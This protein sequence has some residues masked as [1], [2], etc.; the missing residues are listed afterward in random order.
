M[1]GF[2]LIVG[3]LLIIED[4]CEHFT[5]VLFGLL[6]SNHLHGAVHIL[7]GIVGLFTGLRGDARSFCFFLG[8]LLLVVDLLWFLPA[9]NELIVRL[10]SV[11]Q[12][13]TIMNLISPSP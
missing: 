8:A 9:T 11:N 2:A 1:D 6:T 5:P 7:L 4:I 10:F 13:V 3:A 12:P